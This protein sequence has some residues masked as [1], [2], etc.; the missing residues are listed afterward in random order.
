MVLWGIIGAY[1]RH[2]IKGLH[3]E[4]LEI[5]EESIENL[6]KAVETDKEMQQK[7]YVLGGILGQGVKAGLGMGAGKSSSKFGVGDMIMRFIGNKLESKFGGEQPQ[8]GFNQPQN[9]N[10]P[11]A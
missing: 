9:T 6:L 7:I 5:V 11:S 1:V 4:M 10:I 2:K 8:Q 3:A